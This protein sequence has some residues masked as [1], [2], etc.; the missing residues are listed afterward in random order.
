MSHLPIFPQAFGQ[1]YTQ[2]CLDQR[3][4]EEGYH[5]GAGEQ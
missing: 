3:D 4:E 2:T 1:G 5:P